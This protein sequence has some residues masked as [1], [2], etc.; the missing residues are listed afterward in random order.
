MSS[1]DQGGSAQFAGLQA[2]PFGPRG[3]RLRSRVLLSGRQ[4]SSWDPTR[5]VV[6]FEASALDAAQYTRLGARGELSLEPERPG[7]LVFRG[8]DA[9]LEDLVELDA[10]LAPILAAHRLAKAA[11]RPLRIMGIVNVTP[12]SFS[13][14]GRFLGSEE[15]IEHGKRL[16]AAGADL[17]DIGAESTRPGAEPV[18]LED[19]LA[20]VIPVVRGLAEATDI[21][22]SIDTTKAEVARSALAAGA[23]TVNDVSAG[24]VEPAILNTTAEA[25][26]DLVLMHMLG[27][28]RDMQVDPKY[29]DVAGEVIEHLRE[30]V[31]IAWRAGVAI[32]KIQVDPGIG[33]GKRLED[34]L[35]LIRALPELRSLGRPILLG[36]SRKSFLGRLGGIDEPADRLTDTAAAITAGILLGAEI[37][38]V[39]A[40]E[41]LVPAIRVATAL[42]RND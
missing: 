17:L 34:N 3:L 20:R 31:A 12:D 16:I 41:Q 4:V 6:A 39:H 32:P 8:L 22:L 5:V 33:F 23:T 37:L 19:E 36:V 7:R 28:P 27:S 11:P 2:A 35:A 40:V 18:S 21:P 14:G 9:D 15:A 30:R 29:E 26:A 10:G 24:L 1:R 13:D 42:A 38:R 25:D